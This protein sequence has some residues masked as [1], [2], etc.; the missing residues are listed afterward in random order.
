LNAGP[1]LTGISSEPPYIYCPPDV[2]RDLTGEAST[3]Y[4]RI[5]Q[6]KTNVNW[7]DNVKATPTWAK[8]LEAELGLGK[9]L[10]TFQ[11]TSPHSTAES[12][13]CSFSVHVRDTVPPRVYNCPSDFN[14]YLDEGQVK[15]QVRNR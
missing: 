9:T 2:V 14:V 10:V 1:P 4:V 6:P 12:D 13:S 7:Y 11:A 5:P 3:T 15:R 8:E